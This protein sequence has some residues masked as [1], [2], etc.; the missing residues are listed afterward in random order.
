[1]SKRRAWILLL[2]FLIG[3]IAISRTLLL[4]QSVKKQRQGEYVRYQSGEERLP[5]LSAEATSLGRL[6]D[7]LLVL[8]VT[9]PFLITALL[10]FVYSLE[11][12]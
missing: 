8:T 1:M 12:E 11:G 10:L 4:R 7:R 6:L 9:L 2:F 3:V 5:V